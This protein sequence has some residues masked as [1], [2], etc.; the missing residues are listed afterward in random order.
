MDTLR[1]RITILAL[2][3]VIAAGHLGSSPPEVDAGTTNLIPIGANV[4]GDTRG[5]PMIQ[6]DPRHTSKGLVRP[7]CEGA[8][9]RIEPRPTS[10]YAPFLAV[11][12]DGWF[13][14]HGY[15]A[16]LASVQGKRI[17]INFTRDGEQTTCQEIFG[18]PQG[19]IW[20]QGTV[21]RS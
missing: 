9:L 17:L 14:R 7:S 16:G 19:N 5:R 21:V 4:R 18:N 10:R 2:L 6:R 20:I 11:T 13:L 8:Y 15:R 1:Y 3:A 12:V